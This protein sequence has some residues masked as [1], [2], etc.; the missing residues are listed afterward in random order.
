MEKFKND[1]V[2]YLA[3]QAA[4]PNA[5]VFNHFGG[6]NPAYNVLH[7]STCVF[8]WRDS[9][10]GS[11]TAVEKWCAESEL[12]LVGQAESIRGHGMWKRCGVCLRKSQADALITP[13]PRT[14]AA[15]DADSVKETVPTGQIWVAGEPAVWIGSGE[16]EWKAKLTAALQQTLPPVPP[17]WLEVEL[18]LPEA[19]LY[20]KDFDNLLTPVLESA[21]DAGWVERGFAFLGSVTGRKVGVTD[22]KLIGAVITPHADPPRLSTLRTGVLIEVP[23]PGLDAEAVKWTLYDI[24]YDLFLRRPELR[25][26]PQHPLSLEIRVTVNDA[27]RRKSLQS[28]MKP[29]IDGMEP[30]LGHPFNLLP[31][32]RTNLKRPL[33]PQDE[34]VLSLAFHVRGG[35]ADTVAVLISPSAASQQGNMT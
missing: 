4:H 20:R 13:V 8:L 32:S 21:R 25:Y 23:L 26:P 34:M 16:K 12:E 11:R 6:T 9:D 2:N 35:D 30:L 19:K 15:K 29:C 10:E 27:S 28:L 24:S 1:E 5:F 14:L 3:W 22:E 7:R 18:R 17:Q 31:E 33:A